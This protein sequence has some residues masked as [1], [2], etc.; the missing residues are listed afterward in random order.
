LRSVILGDWKLIWNP[1][2]SSELEWALYDLRD[3]P[4]ET[5]NIYRA[6]HPEL[7]RLRAELESWLARARDHGGFEGEYVIPEQ[8]LETLR[9]LGYVE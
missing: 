1:F 4:D 6:D 9:A 3:D 5:R 8:D 7:P 2:Q